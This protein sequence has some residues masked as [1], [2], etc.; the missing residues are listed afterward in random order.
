VVVGFTDSPIV[1]QVRRD[2]RSRVEEWHMDFWEAET[3]FTD[4]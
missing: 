1:V 2:G 3:G 4:E